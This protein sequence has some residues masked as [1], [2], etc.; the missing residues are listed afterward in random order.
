MNFWVENISP[1]T[2][3]QGLTTE[4]LG[5]LCAGTAKNLTIG[6]ILDCNF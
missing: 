6:D 3:M 5:C 2:I 1:R 4:Q